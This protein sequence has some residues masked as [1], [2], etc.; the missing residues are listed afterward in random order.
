MAGVRGAADTVRPTEGLS[1]RWVLLNSPGQFASTANPLVLQIVVITIPSSIMVVAVPASMM[2]LAL[3]VPSPVVPT[4]LWSRRLLAVLRRCGVP[5]APGDCKA[6]VSK[7][8]A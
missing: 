8:D 1:P 6:T 5:P 4:V 7:G 2:L 3:L